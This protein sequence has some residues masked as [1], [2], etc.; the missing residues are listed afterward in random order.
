MFD[1][2]D[3]IVWF[4][5]DHGDSIT[6]LKL[7]KLCYYTEALYLAMYDEPFTGAQFEAYTHGPVF[8]EIHKKYSEYQWEP[9]VKDIKK[10]FLPFEAEEHLK[11]ILDTYFQ[12]N[13]FVLES[14]IRG[15]DPFRNARKGL[16]IT[17]MLSRPISAQHM[18]EYYKKHILDEPCVKKPRNNFPLD[19]RIKKVCFFG[20]SMSC[21]LMDDREIIIPLRWLPKL[22]KIDCAARR[23]YRIEDGGN[24]VYWPEI[25]LS[26]Y[27]EEL[28]E[29]SAD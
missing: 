4:G 5:H 9:I 29:P 13:C 24:G 17:E 3:Y 7:Q 6:T 18:Q 27:P 10:P 16:Q 8:K 21:K 28:L 11:D 19:S 1:I 14:F 26:L 25:K 15:E 23:N 12:H 22:E 2:A 20:S